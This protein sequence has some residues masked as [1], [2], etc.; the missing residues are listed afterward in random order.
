VNERPEWERDLLTHDEGRDPLVSDGGAKTDFGSFGWVLG[1]RHGDRYVEEY[2]IAR[3]TPMA[4]FRAEAYA[5]MSFLRFIIRYTEFLGVE[6]HA[7]I[8]ILTYSDAKG[9]LQREEKLINAG[10]KSSSWYLA[11]DQD[12]IAA[13]EDSHRQMPIYIKTEHVKGHQDKDKAFEQLT[14]P[15]KFN[16][17]ADNLATYALDLAITTKAEP[18]PLLPLPRGSPC[19]IHE[20]KMQTSHKRTLLHS[21]YAGSQLKKYQLTKHNWTEKQ[22]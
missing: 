9:M 4:S 19:L 17:F 7:K 15:E 1:N 10:Y 11:S 3:G 2:G 16:V 20:G 14:I 5:R 8:Q 13:L 12:V 6:I 21:S 18:D 22:H